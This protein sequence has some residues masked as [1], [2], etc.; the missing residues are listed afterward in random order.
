MY[1]IKVMKSRIFISFLIIAFAIPQVIY[2]VWWNPFT[3][4]KPEAEEQSTIDLEVKAKESEEKLNIEST[5][6]NT[7][8][9]MK[10]TPEVEVI[11]QTT[12]VDN[13][14]LQK[15]I[16]ALINENK[17]LQVKYDSVLL[18]LNQCKSSVRATSTQKTDS[19]K[20]EEIDNNIVP[21]LD[22]L[23]SNPI[24]LNKGL[25]AEVITL[26]LYLDAYRI[27]DSNMTYKVDINSVKANPRLELVKLKEYLDLYIKYR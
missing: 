18:E 1:Y 19:E 5:V 25:D 23:L 15:K 27:I 10:K 8:N 17:L 24:D 14:E 6:V 11:T 7:E 20:L 26:N 12:K 21:F 16:N 2:A 3:W 9:E 22:K 4:F 13:P